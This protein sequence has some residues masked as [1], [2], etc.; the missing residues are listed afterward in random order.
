MA[1]RCRDP[2][3]LPGVPM[4]AGNLPGGPMCWGD[5]VYPSPPC[6]AP[7]GWG[8]FAAPPGFCPVQQ[9][10]V[11]TLP[12]YLP[13]YELGPA[14]YEQFSGYTEEAMRSCDRG[15]SVL[16]TMERMVNMVRVVVE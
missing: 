12:S 8:T 2:A 6:S 14:E 4:T 7:P 11:N 10:W 13:S 1:G 15:V 3:G 9:A 5:V 16:N